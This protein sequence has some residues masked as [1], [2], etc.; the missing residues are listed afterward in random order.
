VTPS[1]PGALGR[2]LA[3]IGFMGAGKTTIGREVARLTERPFVDLDEEIARR[4]GPIPQIFA[5]HG[6][7]AF[8]RLE[9]EE[10]ARALALPAPT[11]VALGGGAPVAAGNRRLLASHDAFVV[12][13][14]VD[15]R[16]AWERTRGGG[17]PLA[18]DHDAFHRLYEE[19]RPLY[20]E[21]AQARVA[22]V[23]GVLLAALAIIVERGASTR[24]EELLPGEDRGTPDVAL[25][26]DEHVLGLHP[27]ALA[28]RL[29]ETHPVPAGERAKTA[30]VVESLWRALRLGRD[31]HVV[32]LGGGS[33]TDVAGFVA[34]TYL[35][36]V[37][38]VAV[39]TTLV[40]Q[41]DA[42]IGGKTGIDLPEGKN[43]VGAFHLPALVAVDP[44]L[45]ATL[46]PEERR[47]G[48]A[49][50]VKTGLLAG[51]PLWE[52]DDLELVR[53]AAAFKAAVVLGD[54][55]EEGR[56]AILNLGHT[57]AHALET[58]SGYAVRHGDAVALGLLAA[59]RLSGQPTD[60]VEEVLR[61]EPIRVDRERAWSA[62]GRDK[63][64]AGGRTRVVLLPEPGRPEYGVELP[65]TEVRAAL[66]ALIAD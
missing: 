35:R 30:D 23:A 1:S 46:S 37:E 57:F 22:D 50:V 52:L 24:L 28:R 41:V 61:P 66:D 13:V 15:A 14:D 6:E 8:R 43:L 38:W 51:E 53:R 27:P 16:E 48:M 10:L 44:D 62:L 60:V 65:D 11:V 7:P 20:A 34:A 21:A 25:I 19:R 55:H 42:A 12:W 59:L 5:A 2:H 29:A 36:G 45:L 64:A 49:E 32:A 26:A 4:H 17:R 54:P 33:T 63:K 56:R 31:G 40:G 9:S 47:Q 18:A 39:P 3:L 58:A